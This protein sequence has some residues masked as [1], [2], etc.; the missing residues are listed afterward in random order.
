MFESQHTKHI[1]SLYSS[2]PMAES[3]YIMKCADVTFSAPLALTVVPRLELEGLI[4][5][6]SRVQLRFL[7]R[8]EWPGCASACHDLVLTQRS[9]MWHCRHCVCS[10]AHIIFR[11]TRA[12]VV[13]P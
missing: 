5:S 9:V 7:Q 10:L 1:L 2:E 11:R 6:T 12:L 3:E 13:V 8:P 4:P